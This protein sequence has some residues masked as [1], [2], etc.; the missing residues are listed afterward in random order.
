[1]SN[2][3]SIVE[4]AIANARARLHVV[5]D[6][7]K[8]ADAPGSSH[9]KE[10]QEV[11]DA[12]EFLALS[13]ADD[14]SAA[15]AARGEMVRSFFKLSMGPGSVEH[16]STAAS[17]TQAQPPAG[18]RQKIQ[19]GGKPGDVKPAESEAPA[20]QMP[21]SVMEQPAPAVKAVPQQKAAQQ[22][23]YDILMSNQKSAGAGGPA[24]STAS[25]DAQGIPAGNENANR[26]ALLGSNQAVVD[27]T[28]REAKKPPRARLAEVF[29]SANDTTGAA[30]AKAAF[31]NAAAKGGLKIAEWSSVWDLAVSGELG[32]EVKQAA[33]GIVVD[34]EKAAGRGEEEQVRGAYEARGA[35]R[36]AAQGAVQ[37][38]LYGGLRGAGQG[39]LIGV[40]LGAMAGL[41][42]GGPGVLRSAMIG[43]GAGLIGGGTVGA[44]A[45]SVAGG[46]AGGLRGRRAGGFRYEKDTAEEKKERAEEKKASLSEYSQLWDQVMA[47]QLGEQ[48]QQAALG[49]VEGLAQGA[50]APA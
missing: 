35:A 41:V 47:G 22:T 25:E 7:E 27:A 50:E 34:V 13:T 19:P 48:A 42:G 20:G 45:G 4:R 39:M 32:A 18:S 49:L 9:V 5:S 17:G 16:G 15:G 24:E 8:V 46:I 43:G 28:K 10:A 12:L 1:M 6:V 33:E 23:L 37:G 30:G 40:P 44:G 2:H 3:T 11:A 21:R 31:P 38:G 26:Q 14:G 29:A 36:G